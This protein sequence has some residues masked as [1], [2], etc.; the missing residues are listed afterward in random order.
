MKILLIFIPKEMKIS[1]KILMLPRPSPNFISHFGHDTSEIFSLPF[2]LG[3]PQPKSKE[4]NKF[5]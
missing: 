3:F 1:K 2:S 5:R 4:T